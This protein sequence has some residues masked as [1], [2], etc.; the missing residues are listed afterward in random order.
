MPPAEQAV[1]SSEN[2]TVIVPLSARTVEQLRQRARDLLEFIRAASSQ[3]VD[4]VAV[5]YTLQIGREPM[6]ERL[7]FV[8]SSVAQLAE[9]LSTYINGDKDIEEI[10]PGSC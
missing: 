6:Q 7:G 4:L 10:Y 9:K 5:A 2:K 8:V 3:P 1:P